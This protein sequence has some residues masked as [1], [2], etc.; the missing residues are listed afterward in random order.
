MLAFT[1]TKDLSEE[2]TFDQ[3]EGGVGGLR[4]GVCGHWVVVQL[5]RND[6]VRKHGVS[7]NAF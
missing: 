6:K 1:L 3:V 2:D 7:I 4:Q 5:Q